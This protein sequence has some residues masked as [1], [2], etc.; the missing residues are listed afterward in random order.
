MEQATKSLASAEAGAKKQTKISRSVKT[1]G[2]FAPG[3]EWEVLLAD[4][5]ILN[6]MTN[7]L[8]YVL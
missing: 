3:L 6:G 2:K 4:S 1:T 5:I 7:V 8:R